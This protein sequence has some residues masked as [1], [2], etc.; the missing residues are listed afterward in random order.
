M[1]ARALGVT[2]RLVV[3]TVCGQ[4]CACGFTCICISKECCTCH[5]NVK[6]RDVVTFT[7]FLR[8]YAS[9][10]K[11]ITLILHD[12]CCWDW[13]FF[14]FYLIQD[15]NR[16]CR[17]LDFEGL[18]RRI[19]LNAQFLSWHTLQIFAFPK[20]IGICSMRPYWKPGQLMSR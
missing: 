13:P 3:S 10:V 1:K 20:L 16:W 15:A 7:T 5:G 17:E 19:S 18:Q 12:L 14:R 9:L 2:C 8:W 6:R 4:C 11:Q